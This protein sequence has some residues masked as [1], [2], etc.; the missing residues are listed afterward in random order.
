MRSDEAVRVLLVAVAAAS[1]LLVSLAMP[2][3]AQLWR[4]DPVRIVPA[5]NRA[6][7]AS[8]G[9]V[10]VEIAVPGRADPEAMV[11]DVDGRDVTESISV[12]DGGR[13]YG[14][15]DGLEVGVNRIT[16]TLPDGS[17]AHLDVTNHPIG[18]PIFSGPQI[19]PWICTT[20]ELGM[21]PP[22]DDQCNAPTVYEY[23][24]KSAVTGLFAPY[25]PSSPPLDVATTTTDE[26]HEVPYVVRVERGTINR[27]IYEIAVLFDPAR[28]W[29]RWAQQQ[30]W[31]NKLYWT[32][33]GDC[34]PN[35]VQPAPDE[36]LLPTDTDTLLL[37]TA[38]HDQALSQGFAVAS[39]GMTIL[40]RNCNDV[41]SAETVMMVKE[42]IVEAYGE[43]R[44]TMSQ[45][46]SGG[47]MQ[48][49]W[50]AANYPGLLDGIQPSASYPDIWETMQAAEDCHLMDRVFDQVSP[51]LWANPDDQAEAAGHA[52]AT[53]C[54]SLWDNPTGH[55]RYARTWLDPDGPGCL[56]GVVNDPVGAAAGENP[57]W[58]YDA[59]ANPG[60]ERCTLQDYQVALFGQ[61][62]ADVWST[63]EAELGRGFANRPYDNVGVQYGLAALES[64]EI[65]PEQF[66]DLNEHAGGLDIDWNWQP[67]RS[68]ADPAA[69]ERAYLGGRVTHG[70]ELDRVPIMD[71]RGSSNLEI[72]TDVH[73]WVTRARLDAANGHHDNHVYWN[74]PCPLLPC[75]PVL[76]QSFLTLDAWLAAIEVDDREVPLEQKVVDNKPQ[77][78]VDACWVGPAQITDEATCSTLLP[79]FATPRLTA[80]APMTDDVLKC[81]LKPLERSDFADLVVGFTDGQWARLEAAFPEGV[82]DY[83]KPGVAQQPPRGPWQTYADGPDGQPLGPAPTS[84]PFGPPQ[85]SSGDDSAPLPATGGG[86][87]VVAALAVLAAV[88]TRRQV[89]AD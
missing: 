40:G 77:T 30:Q 85:P 55:L 61:R 67:E 53:T 39:S 10:L 56:G 12:T 64:G 59:E 5:S 84:V 37:A 58:V 86:M 7:L 34:T 72:H 49:H 26:G 75:P 83:S 19:Q 1:L 73:T 32:F 45:G 33:G 66:V 29:E 3:R 35:H 20:E 62:P 48:Q 2:A 43:L 17:G 18:G 24:Y 71:I 8:G 42:H 25:D 76:E 16:V 54:R 4:E 65:L 87:T 46:L 6:D 50:I 27:G 9:D 82:C 31:N 69:L 44:Y 79:Y 47:S 41:I 22:Q 80:G 81:Q 28:S 88:I 51:H 15:I 13:I 89:R 11:V 38:L 23:Q 63:P 36:E 74:T 14:L 21:G 68:V 52:A 60:G 70:G 57:E 78:A